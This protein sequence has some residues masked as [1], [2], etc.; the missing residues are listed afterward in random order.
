MDSFT[1]PTD[2][3]GCVCLNCLGQVAFQA[4]NFTWDTQLGAPWD[5]PGG[6]GLGCL[7][8]I[9]SRVL[10]QASEWKLDNLK[11]EAALAQAKWSL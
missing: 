6:K 2:T 11:L 4:K 7:I 1:F 3:V 8:D 10:V 9:L 5:D